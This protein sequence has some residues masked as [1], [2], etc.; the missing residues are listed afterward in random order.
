MSLGLM[1]GAIDA[2]KSYL[3]ENIAAKL[4]ELDA[5]YDDGITLDDIRNWYVA[6]ASS[7]PAF[8]SVMILGEDT[9]VLGEGGGWMNSGN[10]VS[11]SV[12]V[13]DTN[14]E[15]LRRR[16]YRYIR[17]FIELLVAART[18]DGWTRTLTF[19]KANFSPMFTKSG[20]YL[21]D[22]TLLIT[23]SDIEST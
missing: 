7:M 5:E 1:E 22:A 14:S 12:L 16:L 18:S 23:L 13:G 3:S 8:P 10:R 15:N 11:I 2:L 9:D 6:E 4:D 21:S 19:E 17:A 20:Q